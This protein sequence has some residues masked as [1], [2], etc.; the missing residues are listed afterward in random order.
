M[1]RLHR[2]THWETGDFLGDPAAREVVD[3]LLLPQVD[4][5]RRTLTAYFE[6]RGDLGDEWETAGSLDDYILRLRPDETP[7]REPLSSTPVLARWRDS[8]LP[9]TAHPLT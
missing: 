9:P 6:Q 5:R 3:E 4:S 2:S 8:S 7:L 1:A